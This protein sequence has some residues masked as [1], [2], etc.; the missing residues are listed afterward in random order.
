VDF[1]ERHVA[2]LFDEM[3]A[4]YDQLEDE[5]YPHIFL[6]IERAIRAHLP[7]GEGRRA[8]DIGCGTG[9]QTF[10]LESLGYRTAGLDISGDLLA[11]ARAKAR[12]AGSC[13]TLLRASALRLPF[14]RRSFDVVNCCGSTLSFIADY[15]QA[16]REMADV[17]KKGGYA[18]IEVEQR[19]NLDLIWPFLDSMLGGPFGYEQDV[20]ES[21]DNLTRSSSQGIVISYPFTRLDGSLEYLPIRCFT[22]GEILREC[23]S[24]G[25]GLKRVYG[26]HSL[27]NLLPST[28][29]GDPALG[30]G[31]RR[32][33]RWLAGLEDRVKGIRPFNRLG[34]S[35]ILILEK[36]S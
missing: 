36:K 28:W 2:T 1:S 16:L 10:V 32:L 5:W 33:A 23:E 26:I 11:C 34:C 31:L 27:T 14:P 20:K 7:P 29:L 24:V 15:P 9:F 6:Q 17:L 18:I 30:Q 12:R 4:E 13:I 21:W 22:L 8:L 25:F 35:M 3:A 19:W